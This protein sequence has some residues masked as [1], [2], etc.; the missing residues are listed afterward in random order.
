MGHSHPG[1]GEDRH[2]ACRFRAL[3]GRQDARRPHSQDGYAP[4]ARLFNK[5]NIPPDSLFY[6]K[7]QG[8]LFYF[9]DAT[10]LL[11]ILLVA[12]DERHAA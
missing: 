2:L 5:A 7:R 1:C 8:C 6:E 12:C 9:C 10:A 11:S 3:V 4:S